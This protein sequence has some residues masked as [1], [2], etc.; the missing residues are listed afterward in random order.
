MSVTFFCHQC[1]GLA[2]LLPWQIL[3]ARK[4]ICTQVYQQALVTQGMLISSS[5]W[6]QHSSLGLGISLSFKHQPGNGCS[7]GP[8]SKATQLLTKLTGTTEQF[9]LSKWFIVSVLWH[10]FLFLPFKNRRNGNIKP[11]GFLPKCS[12]CAITF[13][14]IQDL[15]LPAAN[16]Q[17]WLPHIEVDTY[18]WNTF[19]KIICQNNHSL[20]SIN[21][22]QSTP[23]TW[24][25]TQQTLQGCWRVSKNPCN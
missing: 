19:S 17:P 10:L 4:H 25:K 1:P 6:V 18:R 11:P 12:S 20:R 16:W 21:I 5:H 8:H 15:V 3:S 9:R 13:S 22:M 7:V 14:K 23:K 24:L 2:R